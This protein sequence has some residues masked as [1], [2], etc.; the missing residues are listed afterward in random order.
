MIIRWDVANPYT[1]L[2]K[3]SK[4]TMSTQMHYQ[5]DRFCEPGLGIWYLEDDQM[6]FT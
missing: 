3:R 1:K 6:G 4:L 5:E 2:S